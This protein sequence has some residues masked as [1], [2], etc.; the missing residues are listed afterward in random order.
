MAWV[1]DIIQ[2]I[3]T[4]GLYALFACG[5]SLMFGVMKVVNLAHG[6]L[7]VV[8]AY[9]ALGVITVTHIPTLW[10]FVIVVP[11]MALLGY[12]LQRTLIQGALDRSVLTTLL[13]TFGL[14][15]VIE[16]VAAHGGTVQIVDGQ[17][18]GAHFRITM[19]MRATSGDRTEPKAHAHAA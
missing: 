17:F 19:P 4:G 13:V 12:V 2:G 5:L 8:G 3:L 14:S 11:V 9:V 15:V 6:D 1:N 10:S 18:P 7:A 16:F